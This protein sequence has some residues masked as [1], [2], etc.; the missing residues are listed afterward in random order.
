MATINTVIANA[1]YDLRD[2]GSTLYT[3]AELYLYADRALRQL[4]SALSA[5]GS[6]WVYNEASLSLSSG[7]SSVSGPSSCLVIKDAWISTTQLYKKS[8]PTMYE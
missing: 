3:D 1:R 7:D 6:D 5:M 2:T 4:D 8:L